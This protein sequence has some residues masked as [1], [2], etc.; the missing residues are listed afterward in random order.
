MAQYFVLCY[1][2]RFRNFFLR[3]FFEITLPG[4]IA[5][6]ADEKSDLTS[7]SGIFFMALTLTIVSF[8]C[9]GVILGSLMV[10]EVSNGAW[11]LTYG[12][13]GF[14]IALGLPFA[15]FAIFPSLLASLPKSGGWLD[16]VKKTLAFVE[17]ALAF[18]FLS[19]ADLVMHWG[20]LKREVF[21]ALWVATG[22]ALSL[23]LF[24]ILRLPH[25]YK[26]QKNKPWQKSSR[27]SCL[28]VYTVSCTGYNTK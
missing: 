6:K 18:K 21:I 10:G 4:S 16:T 2:S 22:L 20:L 3:F 12:L 24:G 11:P 5:N 9:T 23:Y 27:R 15:L 25:D 26:G 1:L 7:L 17:V 19:S 28:A 13:A 14:G 8:S